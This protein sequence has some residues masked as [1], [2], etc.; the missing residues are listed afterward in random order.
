MNFLGGTLVLWHIRIDHDE[1]YMKYPLKQVT[2]DEFDALERS[3]CFTQ[4]EFREMQAAGRKKT[5][6]LFKL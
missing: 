4:D 3:I 6:K 5:R 2:Q 1:T